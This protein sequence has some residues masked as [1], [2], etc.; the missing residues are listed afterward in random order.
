MR[1]FCG[2][3]SLLL[4]F[5]FCAVA[6][7]DQGQEV[8][9]GKIEV[10]SL[11][12]EADQQTG[13]VVFIGEVV[14]KRND[15]TVYADRMTLYFVEQ[16]AKRK[17]DHL[18]AEGQVRVVEGDRVATANRLYYVQREDKMTLVGDAE[19][20]QGENL[21]SGEE[22]ILFLKENRSFVKSGKEG[23]VK[24]VFLPLQEKP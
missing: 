13:A 1:Y 22:I 11:Q 19:I 6:A 3:L 17:I 4:L 5:P 8:P 2:L 23:R 12:M 14:A 18:D 15:M 7:T 20:H 24:A 21:V 9:A 10:T 16:D